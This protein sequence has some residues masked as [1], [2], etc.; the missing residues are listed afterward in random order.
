MIYN[1][2][3]QSYCQ[4]VHETTASE[5]KRTFDVRTNAPY[6]KVVFPAY[7]LAAKADYVAPASTVPLPFPGFRPDSGGVRGACRRGVA[8]HPETETI[9]RISAAILN[10]SSGAN[11]GRH[12]IIRQMQTIRSSRAAIFCL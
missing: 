11:R 2:N 6:S 8:M 7:A 5:A 4:N 12:D 10:R 3:I 9:D 1:N